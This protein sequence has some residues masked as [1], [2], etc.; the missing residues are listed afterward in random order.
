MTHFVRIAFLFYSFKV[1]QTTQKILPLCCEID[2]AFGIQ[3]GEKVLIEPKFHTIH[4]SKKRVFFQDPK[5]G[6]D[7]TQKEKN[8]HFLSGGVLRRRLNKVVVGFLKKNLKMRAFF[9]AIFWNFVRKY[10]NTE[11]QITE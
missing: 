1:F 11:T 3:K 6:Q 8:V 10:Y 2:F 9:L 4:F 7:N 5:K